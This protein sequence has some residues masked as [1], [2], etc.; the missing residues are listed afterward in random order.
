MG[1]NEQPLSFHSNAVT[2]SVS[3]VTDNSISSFCQSDGS[4]QTKGMGKNGS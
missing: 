1:G 3:M 4:Y 2:P